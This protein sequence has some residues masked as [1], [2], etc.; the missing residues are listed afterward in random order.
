MK[1]KMSILAAL[2]MAVVVT[3]YSVSGTYAKYASSFT[4]TA[5]ATAA[6]WAVT[7]NGDATETFTVDLA[8]NIT[9][10][11]VIA[12]GAA[13]SFDIAIANNGGVAANYEITLDGTNLPTNVKLDQTSATGTINAGESKTVTVGWTWEYT[14]DDENAIAGTTFTA[15][16]TLDVTQVNA[17]VAEV[18]TTST[19]PVEP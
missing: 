8:D 14:E 5:S 19:T 17:P 2:V 15:D 11:D 13:G 16:V 6:A 7:V 9:T 1:K 10:G 18:T 4:G 3:T 12:P